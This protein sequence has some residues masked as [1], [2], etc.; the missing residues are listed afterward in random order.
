[1]RDLDPDYCLD[2]PPGFDDSGDDAQVHPMACRLFPARTA[3]EVFATAE[4]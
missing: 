4:R 2:V 1:M 3:A